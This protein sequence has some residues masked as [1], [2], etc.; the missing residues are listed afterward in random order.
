VRA[1][2]SEALK[3]SFFIPFGKISNIYSVLKGRSERRRGRSVQSGTKTET[4]QAAFVSV[5]RRRG[6][7]MGGGGGLYSDRYYRTRSYHGMGI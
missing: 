1:E 4:V 7:V 6:W 2:K 5:W 3:F